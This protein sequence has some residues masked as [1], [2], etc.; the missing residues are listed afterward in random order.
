MLT[1]FGAY[2]C[3]K[4]FDKR[5]LVAGRNFAFFHRHAEIVV[6]A[7][8]LKNCAG[9]RILSVGGLSK[10]LG[11]NASTRIGRGTRVSWNLAA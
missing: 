11:R 5:A 3:K 2:G 7:A 8:A 4:G 10:L 9:G 6:H 1:L